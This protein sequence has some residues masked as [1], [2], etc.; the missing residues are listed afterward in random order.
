[1]DSARF[2]ILPVLDSAGAW[3]LLVAGS[4][5]WY[6]L[7]TQH[8]L[9]TITIIIVIITLRYLPGAG[10]HAQAPITFH[11]TFS[12][13]YSGIVT[14][15]TLIDPLGRTPTHTHRQTNTLTDPHKHS[16]KQTH[17]QTIKPTN[18]QHTP[19]SKHTHTQTDPR[20]T[21]R[22]INTK[23]VNQTNKHTQTS[24]QTN[25]PTRKATYTHKQA[26]TSTTSFGMKVSQWVY[27]F[28]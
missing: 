7:A 21:H 13:C 2:W 28:N 15:E 12:I 25:Q 16:D 17:Q 18:T 26:H 4:R 1:M 14:H 6:G 5:W 9:S 22:Q 19:T 8:G 27:P 10:A 20:N 24:R 23:T 11:A 3:T